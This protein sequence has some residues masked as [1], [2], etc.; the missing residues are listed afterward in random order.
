MFMREQ[1]DPGLV[2]YLH[3][4][5][6]TVN[7]YPVGAVPM[8]VWGFAVKGAYRALVGE[9][10]KA[11]QNAERIPG[12]HY[13]FGFYLGLVNDVAKAAAVCG[14]EVSGNLAWDL[15]T[16]ARI[17]HQAVAALSGLPAVDVI[18]AGE[19]QE[20]LETLT[21]YRARLRRALN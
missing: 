21:E 12:V 7:Q 20:N 5:V 16:S 8:S 6:E 9:F 1:V 17:I 18:D 10:L 3:G 19:L 11:E 2:D 13:T 4:L 14:T 15:Y